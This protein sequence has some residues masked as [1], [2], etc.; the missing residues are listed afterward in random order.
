MASDKPTVDF[1]FDSHKA[2]AGEK[3]SYV[4]GGKRRTIPSAA[5]LSGIEFFE[6]AASGSDA[7]ATLYVLNE[8]MTEEQRKELREAAPSIQALGKWVQAYL[9]HGGVGAGNA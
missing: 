9:R 8:V 4:I 7:K 3:F 6:A 5:T 2:A 1:N